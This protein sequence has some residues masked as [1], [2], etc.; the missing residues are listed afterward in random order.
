MVPIAAMF[1]AVEFIEANLQ[2]E[3]TIAD[4]AGRVAHSVYHFCRVFGK[5]THHTPYDYL[6]RRRLSESARELVETSRKIIDIA[7][8]YRFNSSETYSRAF[9]RLTGTL[10]YQWRKEGRLDRR[11]LL[12]P[13]TVAHLEHLHR[14][15]SLK[16]ALLEVESLHLAGVMGPDQAGMIDRLWAILDGELP[17]LPNRVQPE[18]YYGLRS[19]P[20]DWPRTGPLYLAAVELTSPIVTTA[21]PVVKTL[22]RLTYARFIHPGPARDLS[23]TLDYIYQTWLP[24]SG[25]NLAASFELE[26]F[27]SCPGGDRR[28]IY[29]PLEI[30]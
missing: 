24:Q 10:P 19:Y 9:K 1:Q 3:I 29:L 18:R 26:A 30:C 5:V 27:G 8:D 6:I 11:R 13:L 21:L 12:S 15:D 22:P 4:V 23:L 17:A 16:P 7:F 2:E 28:E 20:V 14:D 25:R